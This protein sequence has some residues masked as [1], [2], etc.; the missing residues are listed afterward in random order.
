MQ[1]LENIYQWQNNDPEPKG[2][3]YGFSFLPTSVLI[4]WEYTTI[5]KTFMLTNVLAVIG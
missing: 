1:P 3:L 4:S 5:G 2:L